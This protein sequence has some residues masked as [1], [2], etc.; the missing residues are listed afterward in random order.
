M[1]KVNNSNF[2]FKLAYI[3]KSNVTIIGDM[4]LVLPNLSSWKLEKEC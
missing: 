1:L 3:K 2:F 4:V